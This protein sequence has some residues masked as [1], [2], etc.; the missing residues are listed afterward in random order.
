M[1]VEAQ[2]H[3]WIG[4]EVLDSSGEKLGKLEDLYFREDV[5][6]AVSIRSGLGGRKHHVAVLRGAIVSREHLWL[7]ATSDS[8]VATGGDGLGAEHLTKLAGHDERLHGMRPDDIEAW[9]D[10]E[11][12]YKAQDQ[13]RIDAEQLE[14]EAQ[15][16]AQEEDAAAA[17]AR[18][19]EQQA[20]QA[21]RA[22]QEAEARAMQ[23]RED[24]DR[25]R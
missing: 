5:P 21:A 25:D 15:R 2:L 6:V 22:R 9:S 18:E 24:S 8:L 4:T 14:T 13:A 1:T 16:R 17:R 11:E 23:A 7:D 3:T 20:E 10:R 12:R 19:A